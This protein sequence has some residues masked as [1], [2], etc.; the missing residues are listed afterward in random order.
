LLTD[1]RLVINERVILICQ[2]YVS[3]HEVAI[4]LSAREVAKLT[5]IIA[6]AQGLIDKA[7]AEPVV[8]KSAGKK[9]IKR[10]RRTGEELAAFRKMLMAERKRGVPAADLVEQHGVSMTYIY[11]L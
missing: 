7:Q 9:A 2:G 10:T 11:T 3:R 4:S 8:N 5:K 6:L 1:E